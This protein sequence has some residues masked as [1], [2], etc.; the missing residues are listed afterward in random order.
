MCAA[1]SWSKA[2]TSPSAHAAALLARAAAEQSRRK[3]RTARR[4]PSKRGTRSGSRCR[5]SSAPRWG[6]LQFGL[7]G[8][9]RFRTPLPVGCW[10]ARISTDC[11]CQPVHVSGRQYASPR[12][13]ATRAGAFRAAAAHRS[14]LDAHMRRYTCTQPDLLFRTSAAPFR[15]K[16]PPRMRGLR[17][18]PVKLRVVPRLSVSKRPLMV[19]V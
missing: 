18:D 2:P 4:V 13:S 14:R 5:P 9:L 1:W 3:R 6:A 7:A 16:L 8:R 11:V 17:L 15:D 12:R 10:W 19:I